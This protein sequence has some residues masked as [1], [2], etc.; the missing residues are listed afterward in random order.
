[1]GH[2][3]DGYWY[4][5][6]INGQ[7]Y[8]LT[9][10]WDGGYNYVTSPGGGAVTGAVVVINGQKTNLVLNSWGHYWCNS[11]SGWSRCDE[12]IGKYD[13]SFVRTDPYRTA[14]LLFPRSLRRFLPR[15]PSPGFLS[16]LCCCACKTASAG[17]PAWTVSVPFASS[18]DTF[19]IVTKPTG[20]LCRPYNQDELWLYRNGIFVQTLGCK[21]ER[22]SFASKVFVPSGL[23]C[24][25]ECL[26]HQS[27]SLAPRFPVLARVNCPSLACTH[28]P[29]RTDFCVH[30][31]FLGQ[32]SRS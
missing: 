20:D 24:H 27:R 5:D 28:L 8:G 31:P 14:S 32:T 16:S 21:N 9:T 2:A 10:T 18:N 30:P 1:M 12:N 23:C 26:P 19:T 4:K 15:L 17:P 25:A 29:L 13:S 3:G 22:F 6:T 7:T 11:G